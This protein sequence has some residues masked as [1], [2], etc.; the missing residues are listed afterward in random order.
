M[1]KERLNMVSELRT[2]V[3]CM[4]GLVTYTKAAT[5]APVIV[6]DYR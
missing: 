6:I 3:S 5:G 2:E 1:Q 4:L